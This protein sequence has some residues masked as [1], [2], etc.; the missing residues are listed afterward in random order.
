MF[1]DWSPI[2]TTVRLL[3]LLLAI[4]GAVN[5]AFGAGIAAHCARMG[6]AKAFLVGGGAAGTVLGLYLTGVTAY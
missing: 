6:L 1:F 3:G 4:S 2:M 5:V